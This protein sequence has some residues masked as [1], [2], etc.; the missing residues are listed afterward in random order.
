[1]VKDRVVIA[2]VVVGATA[3]VVPG[4]WAFFWPRSFYDNV[5]MFEPYNLHL[6]HDL[7]AFQLGI[8]VALLASLLWRD[9]LFVALV[10]ASTAAVVHA[11]SHVQDRDLGG[12][13]S[14]PWTVGAIAVVLVFALAL[15]TLTHK[16][17]R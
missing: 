2:T 11:V 3:F 17:N 5:A 13:E 6:F 1:M 8:G 9:A 4:A 14:D 10:G 12:R 7:G 16:E 15:R